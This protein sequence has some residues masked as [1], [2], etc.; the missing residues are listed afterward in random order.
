MLVSS[1]SAE[2]VYQ[3]R[4]LDNQVESDKRVLVNSRVQAKALNKRQ[5]AYAYFLREGLTA[6]LLIS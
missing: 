1:Y 4:Y 2:G 6:L 3:S 5:E